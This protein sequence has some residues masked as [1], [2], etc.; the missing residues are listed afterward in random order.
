MG[1]LQERF[2]RPGPPIIPGLVP[3]SQR[4]LSPLQNS[5]EP[6]R[7]GSHNWFSSHQAAPPLKGWG[8]GRKQEGRRGIRWGKGQEVSP[9]TSAGAGVKA[10]PERRGRLGRGCQAV[11]TGSTV[12]A[13][14]GEG[15]PETTE[16]LRCT[17]PRVWG[18]KAQRDG[19]DRCLEG[20]AKR[21]REAEVLPRSPGWGGKS[22]GSSWG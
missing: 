13:R 8:P 18:P 3:Q 9:K 2:V 4:E 16:A 10:G 7:S 15:T 21:S 17:D 22:V 5:R 1:R 14:G 19:G 11:R 20:E 6:C 12:G